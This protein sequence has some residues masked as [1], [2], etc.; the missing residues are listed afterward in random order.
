M[1]GVAPIGDSALL[2]DASKNSEYLC[3]LLASSEHVLYSLDLVRGGYDYISPIAEKIYGVG[4]AELHERGMELLLNELF[5]PD[6][7]ARYRQHIRD[8]CAESPGIPIRTTDEYRLKNAKGE[9]FWHRNSMTLLSDADGR[10]LRAT[11]VTVD[12]TERRRYETALRDSEATYRATMD[13][14]RVGI[15]TLQDFKFQFVNPKLCEMFGYSED[16]CVGKLGPLDFMPVE[17]HEMMIDKMRRRAAGER[18]EPHEVLAIRKDGSRVPIMILG[19]PSQLNGRPASVGTVIDMSEQ[20]KAE[21]ELKLAA[22]VFETSH[23]S[24]LL[25]DAE[26]NIVSVNPG[27]VEMTGYRAD[28]VIGKNP[29]LLSSGK[30]S[31]DFFTAMW[32][33]ISS[34]DKWQGEL[35]NR[36]K[37]GEIF[38]VWL[39]ISVYRDADGN[40]RNYVGV[41]TDISERI[42]SQE[43]IRQL[44]YFDPLTNLPNRR[45]LQDRAE[46]ALASVEREGKQLALMFID[47]DHFKTINDSLGHSVG[48]RLLAEVARRLQACVRRADT[49]AR[50]GGD[51]FV[52]LLSEVTSDAAAEVAR[53][54][55]CQ[56]ARPYQVEQHELGV[57]PSLGISLF[58]QD[59]R[60]FETLLK[61]A[62]T[63]MYQAKETGRNAYQFFT[64]EMNVAALERLLLENSLRQALERSEFVLHYQPQINVMTG[65]IIGTEALIRWQH[66]Q[67]GLVPPGK[68]IPVAEAAGLI[69]QIGEWVLHE[70]CRQNRAWQEAGL[71]FIGV[72]VN[73]S[74][75]QFRRGMLEDS[76]RSALA[77]SEMA[78]E[79]LELELTEGVVMSSA[80]ETVEILRRLSAMGVRLAIDDFGTGYSNLSYLKRFPIDKLKIDQSFVRDIVTDPDDW[81]IANAVINLGHSLRLSVIAEGVEHAEQLEMLR[82]QGCDEVQGYHFSIPLPADDFA[83]LLRQQKFSR[84]I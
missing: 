68:F 42:A 59:G 4:L 16:E 57:T 6:A 17:L 18:G 28:E 83:E 60:D 65:H 30:H 75:V 23:E 15:Y 31:P 33:A 10:P 12:I 72:S 71:P 36:R 61:H 80:D 76:V 20:R 39:T 37:N 62:D 79:W 26:A 11:G 21:R 55:L 14:V 43:R 34:A 78:A 25:T 64:G 45:L 27:F 8:L 24:I 32:Q 22:R 66:P 56:V 2:P 29:R 81:A 54:I 35:W 77:D 5:D 47:L 7:V 19:E 58:P 52:V 13:S 51:E 40:V 53:K 38:P 67:I 48:D 41:A 3:E 63:A 84:R 70:A 1:G 50:I 82:H 44:A 49:V 9:L 46:Q 69:V 73:I 74:S